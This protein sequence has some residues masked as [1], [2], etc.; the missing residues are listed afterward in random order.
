MRLIHYTEKK[1]LWKLKLSFIWFKKAADSINHISGSYC[2]SASKCT[3]QVKLNP[4]Y[5][6]VR[7]LKSRYTWCNIQWEVNKNPRIFFFPSASLL[8][9]TSEGEPRRPREWLELASDLRSRHRRPSV[10]A[11]VSKGIVARPKNRSPIWNS[12]YLIK[13]IK[14]LATGNISTLF[15]FQFLLFSNVCPWSFKK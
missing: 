3:E 5:L 1:V 4:F 9:V 7:L 2:K 8:P 14:G 10:A 15:V 12:I 11:G 6:H 13:F